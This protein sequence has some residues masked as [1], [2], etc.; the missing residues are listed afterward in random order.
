MFVILIIVSFSKFVAS[1]EECFSYFANIRI[2][3][4]VRSYFGSEI[5]W[6]SLG[7]IGN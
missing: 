5:A 6:R 4:R 2:Y 1:S 7:L 3:C